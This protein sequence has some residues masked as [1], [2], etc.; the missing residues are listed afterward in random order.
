M[1]YFTK[2][3][4]IMNVCRSFAEQADSEG[5]SALF[6]DCGVP[7]RKALLRNNF[8]QSV[9]DNYSIKYTKGKFSEVESSLRWGGF[10]S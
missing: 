6:S 8:Q 9:T 1:E 3:V 7:V 5:L 4:Y 10:V 2:I